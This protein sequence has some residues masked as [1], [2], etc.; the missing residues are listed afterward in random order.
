MKKLL[1]K[2]LLLGMIGMTVRADQSLEERLEEAVLGA[3]EIQVNQLLR[4]LESDSMALGQKKTLVADLTDLADGVLKKKKAN[5]WLLGNKKDFAMA[6]LGSLV[7]SLG[8]LYFGHTCS[9]LYEGY[10]D[11]DETW[12]DLLFQNE[13][14]F[15]CY[16]GLSCVPAFLG[17]YLAYKGLTCSSQRAV[18][19]KSRAIRNS[20]EEKKEELEL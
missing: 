12:E 10:K 8:L 2:G 5:V 6:M 9:I 16:G 17:A 13:H 15:W 4:H 19:E 3:N 18:I 20:L 11:P 1:M 7:G 14:A